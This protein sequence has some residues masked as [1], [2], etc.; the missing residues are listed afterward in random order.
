MQHMEKYFGF[1]VKASNFLEAENY[2]FLKKR[3]A[4][5]ATWEDFDPREYQ[6]FLHQLVIF[7]KESH[8]GVGGGLHRRVRN[9]LL[10]FSVNKK[11]RD[12]GKIRFMN[13]IFTPALSEL[14]EPAYTPHALYY[15]IPSEFFV[16]RRSFQN[17]LVT[18]IKKGVPEK[19]KK[20]KI[21]VSANAT[22]DFM[23]VLNGRFCADSITNLD[24][25]FSK[26]VLFK[27]QIELVFDNEGVINMPKKTDNQNTTN[28]FYINQA[29]VVAA[30]SSV[31]KTNVVNS[32]QNTLNEH[33]IKELKQLCAQ[34]SIE[35]DNP[36]ASHEIAIIDGAINELKNGRPYQEILSKVSKW[37]LDKADKI[38]VTLATEAIKNALGM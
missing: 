12:S 20:I 18:F 14:V 28:N 6:I 25:P 8:F 17:A 10:K 30:Q 5:F 37:V 3:I 7:A 32:Q 29:G 27:Q 9:V 11:Q 2:A 33:L 38:G 34:L 24:L 22:P 4:Q 35:K 13:H 1:S 26:A 23:A 15:D 31:E 16:Q 19:F 36:N 21:A